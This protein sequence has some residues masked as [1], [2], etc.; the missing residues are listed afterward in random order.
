MFTTVGYLH[1]C[2]AGARNGG[3]DVP[4]PQPLIPQFHQLKRNEILLPIVA[5]KVAEVFE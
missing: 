2:F 3:H 1:T 4:N 5:H